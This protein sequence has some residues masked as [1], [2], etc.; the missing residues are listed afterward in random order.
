VPAET[1]DAANREHLARLFGISAENIYERLR[2][3]RTIEGIPTRDGFALCLYKQRMMRTVPLAAGI[4]NV[5]PNF[6]AGS[7]FASG[8][9][10]LREL[11]PKFIGPIDHG[12]PGLPPA[13]SIENLHQGSKC[14]AGETDEVFRARRIEMYDDRIPHRHKSEK[15]SD[16][17]PK[18]AINYFAWIDNHSRE[19]R[20]TYVQSREF[21]CHFYECA[22]TGA[23]V[24]WRDTRGAGDA[25]NPV[26]SG[27]ST[28]NA[29]TYLRELHARVALNICGFDAVPMAPDN[30][31]A[32][33]LDPSTPFGHERVLYTM[34]M[35]PAS[36]YP[37]RAHA[38]FIEIAP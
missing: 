12:Q 10:M 17:A 9:L 37:W 35:V 2:D 34:L 28:R 21:Y 31:D 30:I 14:L 25:W 23:S 1:R 27:E 8:S 33:Y 32:A 4:L 11:S 20:L 36:E 15:Y 7:G 16:L 19:H 3:H 22:L 26:T 6:R 29:F 38:Q 24:R 5:F 18:S 13:Q